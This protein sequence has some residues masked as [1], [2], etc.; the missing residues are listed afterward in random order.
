MYRSQWYEFTSSD[1]K[2]QIHLLIKYLLLI[3]FIGETSHILN[4]HFKKL[5][6]KQETITPTL[7][8]SSIDSAHIGIDSAHF[9]TNSPFVRLNEKCT[10]ICAGRGV[11]DTCPSSTSRR[12]KVWYF[13]NPDATYYNCQDMTAVTLNLLR[14]YIYVYVYII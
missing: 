10:S 4:D 8:L 5:E 7:P 2:T 12:D 13:Y 3:D 1:N 14:M 9:G 6:Q 11:F